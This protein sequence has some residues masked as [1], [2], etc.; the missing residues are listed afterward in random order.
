VEPLLRHL[1]EEKL[2]GKRGGGVEKR[3]GVRKKTMQR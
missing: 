2:E 1:L 3:K